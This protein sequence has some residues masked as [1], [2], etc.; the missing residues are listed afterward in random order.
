MSVLL[1]F[2]A[3]FNTMSVLLVF[4]ATFN[5]MSVLLVFMTLSKLWH[6]EHC[7]FYWC[8]MP[9]SILSHFIGV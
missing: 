6:F 3:T 7:Q 9:L 8:L 1:V 2:N 4:N 5:T